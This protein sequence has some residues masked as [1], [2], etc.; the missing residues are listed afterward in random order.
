MLNGLSCV[1]CDQGEQERPLLQLTYR[2]GIIG[3]TRSIYLIRMIMPI[4]KPTI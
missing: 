4:K 1:F 2:D 3:I